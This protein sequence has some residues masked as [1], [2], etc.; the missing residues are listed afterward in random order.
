MTDQIDWLEQRQGWLGLRGIGMVE[1]ERQ[2][3]DQTTIDRRY[4]LCSFATD[5]ERFAD[6]VRRH[7]GVENQ[8]HWSLDMGFDEDQCRVR[9]RNAAENLAVI[10][11]ISLNMLRQESSLKV[12]LKAKRRKAGWDERYLAKIL[13]ANDF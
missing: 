12:G 8:L 5:V 10:R 9:V 1:S 6:A 4:Y 2:I 3:G 7:W 13:A 11:H